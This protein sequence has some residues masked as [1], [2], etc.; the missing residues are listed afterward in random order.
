MSTTNRSSAFSLLK[1]PFLSLTSADVVPVLVVGAHLLVGSGLHQVAPRGQ[2]DTASVLQVLG[3]GLDEV[4]RGDIAHG[5][6]SGLVVRH[7]AWCLL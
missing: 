3:V 1:L 2:L 4:S 6:S 5:D 7:G